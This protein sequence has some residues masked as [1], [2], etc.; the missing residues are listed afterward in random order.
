MKKFKKGDLV[1]GIGCNSDILKAVVTREPFGY[2]HVSGE[3]IEWVVL[4]IIDSTKQ[5]DIGKVLSVFTSYVEKIS[6]EDNSSS[7]LKFAVGDHVKGISNTYV[8]TNKKLI[9]AEVIAVHA[10]SIDIK[11]IR[12]LDGRTNNIG[13]VATFADPDAFDYADGYSPVYGTVFSFVINGQEYKNEQFIRDCKRFVK[14][15]PNDT[16]IEL[17]HATENV[18]IVYQ[19]A[20]EHPVV[21]NLDHYAEEFGWSE[22]RKKIIADNFCPLHYMAGYCPR[23]TTC[24]KCRKWWL[25]EYQPKGAKCTTQ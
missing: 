18:L 11:C 20:Q 9:D 14:E 8:I 16:N 10:N 12:F 13:Y 5:G 21:T 6:A 23:H 19:W 24:E 15:F 22:E 3:E 1:K 25:Q 7:K 4:K 17:S 2:E